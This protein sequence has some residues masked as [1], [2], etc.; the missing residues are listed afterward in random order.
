MFRLQTFGGLQLVDSTGNSVM[1]QRRRLALLAL[2]A[3]AGQRGMSRDKLIALLWPESPADK[4]RHALEQLLY[5]VRRQLQPGDPLVGSDPLR[6]DGDVLTTDLD[7]F[8]RAIRRGDLAEAAALY[9][10]PFLDGFFLSDASEFEQWAE[11]ERVRLRAEHERVLYRL[12]KEAGNAGQQTLEIDYWEQLAALDPLSE[13][14]ALGLARA[15]A[16]AGDWAGAM[17]QVREFEALVQREL[18]LPASPEVSAF[19]HR[20]RTEHTRSAGASGRAEGPAVGGERYRIE[21]E[22][23]R[24]AVAI[25]YLA[26]DLKHDRPVALKRLRPELSVSIEAKR[27]LREIGILAR[28]H[29][30]HILPLYDSGMMEPAEGGQTPFYVM[31]FVEGESLRDHMAGATQLPLD[32]AVTIARDLALALAY[33]HKE[34]F[35]HR[36]VKPENVLLEGDHA[37]VA[38]FGIAHALDLV[39]GEALSRSGVSL[40]TPAYISPEQ[41]AGTKVDGRSDIYS[42]GCVLY[43]ML[44]GEPPFTGRTPQIVLARQ[45]ADPAPPI[46]TLR[47]TIPSAVEIAVHRALGKDPRDRFPDAAAFARALEEV[48][49]GSRSRK[50]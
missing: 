29:H 30:P 47:P 9:R 31:P 18:A 49:A 33:A 21:R 1:P 34:G 6:L 32:L 35:V 3:A 44:A 12:A 27:F 26:R 13:R 10:G 5:Y 11:S 43:E 24:G 8:H 16:R 4:A 48:L 22:V 40:G 46:R 41:I 45:A 37:W 50:S 20:I 39:A 38:D 2:L 36:D 7:Q 28:L 23:G 17:Q 14:M 15:L 25:V 42:L 19:L